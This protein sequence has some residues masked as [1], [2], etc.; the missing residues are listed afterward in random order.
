MAERI[1]RRLDEDGWRRIRNASIFASLKDDDFRSVASELRCDV[2]DKGQVL[3][4]EDE[5]A[6]AFYLVLEGWILLLRDKPDG[7]RTVIKILGPGESFAEALVAEGERYPVTAEAA[8]PCRV[9]R[10]DCAR[11]RALVT[12]NPQI[13][14]AM[15]AATFRQMRR[16]VD[17]IE[18]LKSWPVERRVART[19]LEM[20]GRTDRNACDF[21]L[22]V[23]QTLIAARLS[24]TPYTLSRA[25]KKLGIVGVGA[26]YGR[27]SI[28]DMG[29]LR[30]YADGE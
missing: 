8:S 11:F 5:L 9:A 18:H 29:R 17:Q 27:I 21:H 2:Y 24:I 16:L 13:G 28:R 10:F 7:S 22:P 6:G 26:S 4:H 15:I 30:A 14:L 25:L 12:A 3:F 19:L 23:E 20:C 1:S